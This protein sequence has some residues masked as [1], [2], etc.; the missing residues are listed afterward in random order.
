MSKRP[1]VYDQDEPCSNCA[2]RQF[3]NSAVVCM[4]SLEKDG[5]LM[6]HHTEVQYQG[7]SS[8]HH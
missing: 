7:K 4:N 6:G 5:S 3:G 8:S 2:F 1:C